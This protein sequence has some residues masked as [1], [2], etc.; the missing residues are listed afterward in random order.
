MEW[1]SLITGTHLSAQAVLL[2]SGNEGNFPEDGNSH[3]LDRVG[4]SMERL[5]GAVVEDFTSTFVETIIMER[6]KLA[7]YIMRAPFLLSEPPR[8]SPGRRGQKDKDQSGSILSLSPDLNDTVHAIS[9]CVQACN[10]IMLKLRNTFESSVDE[11]IEP[12]NIEPSTMLYFGS[13]SILDALKFAI[14][15]KLLDIAIDPQGMT[16][17][18]YLSGALQFKH[19][20]TTFD[21]LFRLG[22]LGEGGGVAAN[23]EHGP[24]ER[25]VTASRLL[26]LESAQLQAIREAFNA[27]AVPSSS[28]GSIFGRGDES[29]EQ[30]SVDDEVVNRRL[31]VAD[32]Y[33]DE[34]LLG[35][36]TNMLEAKGFGA[37]SLDEALSI[38]NRRC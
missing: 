5:C 29:T 33:R 7:S 35:E 10:S 30:Y 21:S 16:P 20:V 19:D 17:E 18:L 3:V 14:G 36:A 24:M 6:A 34:R 26:S 27:L 38:I 31:N 4:E 1:A 9:I 11:G 12:S 8:D 15:Q 32:F 13:R 22:G 37:L 2:R 23:I 28:I 25:V